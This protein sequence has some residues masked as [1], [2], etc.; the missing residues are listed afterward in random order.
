MSLD[1]AE[2]DLAKSP[3]NRTGHIQIVIEVLNR[4]TADL[5]CDCGD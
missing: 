1:R 3:V 5:S 2:K 4:M